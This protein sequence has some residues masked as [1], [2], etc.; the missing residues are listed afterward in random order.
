MQILYEKTA[1]GTIDEVGTRL[2]Q[3]TQNHKFGVL[4]I[5]DLKAKMNDKGVAFGPECRVYEVCNPQRAKE[6][7]EK[8]LS[9]ATALPC[10]IAL[11][12]E[13]DAVKL[14]TL[15]PTQVLGLFETPDLAP[16]AK[17]VEADIKAIM[18]E[19]AS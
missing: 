19:A 11:Y 12:Q 3:A 8:N 5:V 10:R 1:N 4:N 13:G 14:S 2:E 17:A 7:L 18:D 16:V 9:I 15:L 6:V